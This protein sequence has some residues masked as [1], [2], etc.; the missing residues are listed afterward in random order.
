MIRQTKYEKAALIGQRHISARGYAI[1][2]LLWII[3]W[4][5]L[6]WVFLC[7]LP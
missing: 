7:Y 2:F 1:L 6:F 4:V 3:G 5:A